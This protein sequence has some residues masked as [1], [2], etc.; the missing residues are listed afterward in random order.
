MNMHPGQRQL[1][2]DGM[3]RSSPAISTQAA[4]AN[5]AKP[6]GAVCLACMTAVLP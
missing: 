6:V 4:Q 1:Y 2:K 5:H 3:S